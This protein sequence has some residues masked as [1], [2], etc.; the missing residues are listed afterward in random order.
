MI[1]RFDVHMLQQLY[2]I[3]STHVGFMNGSGD[4]FVTVEERN[5]PCLPYAE[6]CSTPAEEYREGS[7]MTWGG[8]DLVLYWCSRQHPEGASGSWLL[9]ELDRTGQIRAVRTQTRFH[10]ADALVASVRALNEGLY[11]LIS[12]VQGLQADI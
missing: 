11:T 10:Q 3:V 8:G 7:N 9:W 5:N 2:F 4:Y 12:C 1:P 6:T